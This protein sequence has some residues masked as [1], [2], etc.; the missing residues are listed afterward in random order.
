MNPIS[1]LVLLIAGVA[2]W[3]YLY[4]KSNPSGIAAAISPFH[5]P[6]M[7]KEL[8]A[9]PPTDRIRLVNCASEWHKS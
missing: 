7:L 9:L 2:A 1:C 6:R 4:P 3:N 5:Q 8:L